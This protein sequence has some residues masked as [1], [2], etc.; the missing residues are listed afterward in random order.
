MW[1]IL[2]YAIMTIAWVSMIRD[3]FTGPSPDSTAP[4][5]LPPPRTPQD[6]LPIWQRKY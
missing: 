3:A 5:S 1:I 2:Y 6:N 4:R